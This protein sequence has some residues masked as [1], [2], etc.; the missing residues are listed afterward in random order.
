MTRAEIKTLIQ[1]AGHGTDTDAAQNE[2]IRAAFNE[3][4]GMRQWSWLETVQTDATT[5]IGDNTVDGLDT[6]INTVNEV[7]LTLGSDAYAP[8]IRIDSAELLRK[9]NED[10]VNDVPIWYAEYDGGLLVHPRPNQAYTVTVHYIQV[11]AEPSG[12]AWVPPFD[13]NFHYVLAWGALRYLSFR[14]R[15]WSAYNMATAEFR[16]GVREMAQADNRGSDSDRV[17]PWDGWSLVK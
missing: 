12:D 8:L 7:F 14:Q 11:P 3:L 9:A 4:A 15:D 10:T 6:D 17:E 5:T 13:A 2:A 1:A 16:M